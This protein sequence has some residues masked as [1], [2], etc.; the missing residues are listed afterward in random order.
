MTVS[1]RVRVIFSA[2]IAFLFYASW[3]YYANQLVSD[4]AYMLAKVSLVQGSY[5]AF[6]T[7]VFSAIIEVSFRQVKPANTSFSHVVWVP[8][9][10]I[11]LQSF[12]VIA[13]NWLIKTP[14][15][16]LTVSPSIAFSAIYAYVYTFWL[17]KR[18]LIKP[19]ASL[20]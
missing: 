4:D 9:P 3:A 7:L 6:V 17:T 11:L 1:A 13:V 19:D 8:L 10:A 15:L 18:S 5:S 14:N 16:W 20:L 2:S 12:F